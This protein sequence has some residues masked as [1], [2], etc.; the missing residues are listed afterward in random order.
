MVY[1]LDMSSRTSR[2]FTKLR[3]YAMEDQ[4]DLYALA[5]V[6]FIFTLMGVTGIADIRTLSSVIL[7]FLAVLATSQV[8]SRRM[9]SDLARKYPGSKQLLYVNP[10]MEMVSARSRASSILFIG[11][12]MVKTLSQA[13]DDIRR[14]LLSGGRVR[15]LLLD[16][17]RSD[18]LE[19]VKDH[20]PGDVA[21]GRI[22]ESIKHSVTE[23]GFLWGEAGGFLEVRVADFV[24]RSGFRVFD[25]GS[26][27]GEVYIQHYEYRPAQE[28]PVVLRL[29]AADGQWYEYFVAEAERMWARGTPVQ[30][31]NDG[32]QFR[33]SQE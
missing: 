1:D 6:A 16:Y 4:F 29:Q 20:H 12:S 5:L 30:Y 9:I 26:M 22:A 25:S 10:P 28:R 17:R 18:L 31:A 7:A 14:I 27:S 13:R 8:R 11:V 3:Q 2:Y 32:A 23:M 21:V 19:T 24:P 33:L 15:I